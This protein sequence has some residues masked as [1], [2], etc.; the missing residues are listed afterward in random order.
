MTHRYTRNDPYDFSLV[1]NLNNKEEAS[2]FMLMQVDLDDNKRIVFPSPP[3]KTELMS[4]KIP[5]ERHE[6]YASLWKYLTFVGVFA[7]TAMWLYF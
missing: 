1:C 6:A 5:S 7:N 2:K 3:N 4:F